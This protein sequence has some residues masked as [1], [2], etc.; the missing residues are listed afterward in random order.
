MS[1]NSQMWE[2]QT[3]RFLLPLEHSRKTVFN[4][5]FSSCSTFLFTYIITFKNICAILHGR[6]DLKLPDEE[7]NPRP[8]T[9]SMET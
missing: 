5:T 3:V 9:G 8:Y 6:W 1:E 7:L 2:N 4:L